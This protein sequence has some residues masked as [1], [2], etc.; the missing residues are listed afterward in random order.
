MAEENP[1]QVHGV[2]Y[3]FNTYRRI[4]GKGVFQVVREVW[5]P[6]KRIIFN[7]QNGSWNAFLGDAPRRQLPAPGV[8]DVPLDSKNVFVPVDIANALETF[9]HSRRSVQ[10]HFSRQ[11]DDIVSGTVA[12]NDSN[13]L[14]CVRPSISL[15]DVENIL[16]RLERVWTFP[17]DL[18]HRNDFDFLPLLWSER[19]RE[20]TEESLNDPVGHSREYIRLRDLVER[21]EA[22]IYT[23]ECILYEL[24]IPFDDNS[25]GV[26][27]SDQPDLYAKTLGPFFL[28]DPRGRYLYYHVPDNESLGAF[29]RYARLY[30]NELGSQFEEF[31]AVVRKIVFWVKDPVVPRHTRVSLE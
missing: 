11:I 28:E 20:A 6:S 1:T 22:M 17:W 13:P 5:I 7:S 26:K 19:L 30:K 10:L 31:Q 9:V 3:N 12:V 27:P 15:D 18:T 2:S 23:W 16:L 24:K 14:P 25:L 21:R 4:N 29:P 8:A